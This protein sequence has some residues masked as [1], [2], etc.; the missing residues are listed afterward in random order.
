MQFNEKEL[1]ALN[2]VVEYLWEKEQRDYL[3]ED[4]PK[5][6]IFEDLMILDAL[7]TKANNE[8]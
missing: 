6:H 3:G 5:G 7:T 4:S 2:N 1:D 8:R